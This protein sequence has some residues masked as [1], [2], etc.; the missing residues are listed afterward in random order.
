MGQ[1]WIL[2]TILGILSQAFESNQT[3]QFGRGASLHEQLQ[4]K[5]TER[6]NKILTLKTVSMRNM[7]NECQKYMIVMLGA[8]GNVFFGSYYVGE[9][10]E[11][12]AK[13]F[14]RTTEDS[15]E[16]KFLNLIRIFGLFDDL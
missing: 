9:S 6:I 14:R 16:R 2:E 13:Q 7:K 11:C 8:D 3:Y 1:K 12:N 15:V 4:S 5:T 10:N